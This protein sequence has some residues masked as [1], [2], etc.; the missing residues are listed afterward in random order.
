MK[1]K[2][3]ATIRVFVR[4]FAYLKVLS[5]LFVF[6]YTERC[7]AILFAKR[8]NLRTLKSEFSQLDFILLCKKVVGP[9]PPWT[10][11]AV[12]PAISVNTYSLIL[13]FLKLLVM[14]IVVW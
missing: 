8:I 6:Q 5:C 2:D 9:W 10:P 7:N 1:G 13:L 11:V 12:A 4:V 14:I 3:D